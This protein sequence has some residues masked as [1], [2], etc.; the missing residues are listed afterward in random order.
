M[1]RTVAAFCIVLIVL[2]LCL[3]GIQTARQI[4][5]E[6]V[7]SLEEL[8]VLVSQEDFSAALELSRSIRESWVKKHRILCLY[9][10]H[11]R[12]EKIDESMSAIIPL[13]QYKESGHILSECDRMIAQI[14]DLQESE[15]PNWENIL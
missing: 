8:K 1:K 13:I 15:S 7:A 4:T 2:L 9:M 10:S 6:A 14:Q 12:L 3:A 11:D 5:T